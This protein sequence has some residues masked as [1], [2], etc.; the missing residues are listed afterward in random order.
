[1]PK[2]L[3]VCKGGYKAG[4]PSPFNPWLQLD[5]ENTTLTEKMETAG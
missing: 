2:D 1:M 3:E 4:L 5:N